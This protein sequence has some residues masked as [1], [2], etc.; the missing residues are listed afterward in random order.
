MQYFGTARWSASQDVTYT[1][2]AGTSTAVSSGVT[3][4]RLLATTDC[5]VKVTN[6]GTAAISTDTYLPGLA[7]EYITVSGGDKISAI[8]V[9]SAGTLNITE[10]P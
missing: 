3:K 6:A 2:T 5:R 10:A 1:G 8:Q 4:V 9:S 7:A